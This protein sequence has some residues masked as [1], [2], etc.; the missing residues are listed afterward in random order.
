MKFRILLLSVAAVFLASLP[1]QAQTAVFTVTPVTNGVII[2]D[3][4]TGS[5]NHCTY[6]TNGTSFTPI[7]KC[8][9]LG[10]NTPS[11]APLSITTVGLSVFVTNLTTGLVVQCSLFVDANGN[12]LGACQVEGTAAP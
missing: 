8:K 4:S 7:G 10:R 12:P 1:M 11:G 9:L 6:T 2:V 3:T 5:I